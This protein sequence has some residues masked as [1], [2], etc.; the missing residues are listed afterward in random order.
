MVLARLMG[1]L[2]TTRG[3]GCGS[4]LP[5]N[6]LGI[7]FSPV[8]LAPIRN[9]PVWQRGQALAIAGLVLSLLSMAF[10]VVPLPL[11]V[12]LHPQGIMHGVRKF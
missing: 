7:I 4:G 2:T 10:G 12:L 1:V 5:F 8:A 9:D 11:G 3:I 6:V